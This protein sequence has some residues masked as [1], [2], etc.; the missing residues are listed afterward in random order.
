[1]SSERLRWSSSASSL[2][3]RWDKYIRLAVA[4]LESHTG[5]GRLLLFSQEVDSDRT[6]EP[7]SHDFGPQ[8]LL[9]PYLGSWRQARPRTVFADNHE[10]LCT[11]HGFTM[12]KN[13]RQRWR[14]DPVIKPS[15]APEMI[16]VLRRKRHFSPPC[17]KAPGAFRT[18]T[19]DLRCPG[20]PNTL[21]TTWISQRL[22]RPRDAKGNRGAMYQLTLRRN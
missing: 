3:G 4:H 2:L 13:A 11:I 15:L 20:V 9:L 5:P 12:G 14:E 22:D 17:R 21:L 1:M 19:R 8:F 7:K 6:I 16:D 18:R 10:L